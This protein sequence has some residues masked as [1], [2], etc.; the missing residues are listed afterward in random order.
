MNTNKSIFH[1]NPN[2][3][4]TLVRRRSQ[5]SLRLHLNNIILLSKINIYIKTDPNQGFRKIEK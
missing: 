3:Y 4:R 1:E 2:H 5:F